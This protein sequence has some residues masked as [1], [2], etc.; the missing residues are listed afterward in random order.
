MEISEIIATRLDELVA[1]VEAANQTYNTLW[2]NGVGRMVKEVYASAGNYRKRMIVFIDL[3]ARAARDGVV[4]LT[5]SDDPK[6]NGPFGCVAFEVEDVAAFYY[7]TVAMVNN[8]NL[9]HR[10]LVGDDIT[11][12]A[13]GWLS[14]HGY[15]PVGPCVVV[16]GQ[17]AMHAN[18]MRYEGY[19][20]F[21]T[22][23]HY[24]R[25]LS[26]K[27]ARQGAAAGAAGN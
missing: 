17:Y 8:Q 15:K 4:T 18:A 19:K 6:L 20:H 2:H 12:P 3:L 27:R 24:E 14:L 16:N 21:K 23:E 11:E 1:E 13:F 9:W 25:L 5:T 7:M 22:Q 26:R 10:P